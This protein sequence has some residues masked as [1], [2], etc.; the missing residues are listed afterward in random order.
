MRGNPRVS[1]RPCPC[2]RVCAPQA[3]LTSSVR[4]CLCMCTATL[5][6]APHVAVGSGE[7]AAL[8][9]GVGAAQGGH[10][11]QHQRPA[12]AQRPQWPQCPGLHLFQPRR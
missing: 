4:M 1:M 12:A 6:V 5:E 11:R 2:A 8:P 7:Q 3:A 10:Q 9:A